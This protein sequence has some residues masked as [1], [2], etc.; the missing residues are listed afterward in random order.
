RDGQAG[1]GTCEDSSVRAQAPAGADGGGRAGADEDQPFCKNLHCV[2]RNRAAFTDSTVGGAGHT[3][4]GRGGFCKNFQSATAPGAAPGS[5]PRPPG[6]E[7]TRTAGAMARVAAVVSTAEPVSTVHSSHSRA[8][9]ASPSTGTAT[10]P[11]RCQSRE[12]SRL[13]GLIVS[14]QVGK[15]IPSVV[16]RS[17][18]RWASAPTA[19]AAGSQNEV[20]GAVTA[21]SRPA[22][23]PATQGSSRPSTVFSARVPSAHRIVISS[24]A[25]ASISPS[26]GTRTCQSSPFTN[27]A[28]AV[29]ATTASSVWVAPRCPAARLTA[30]E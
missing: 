3:L 2:R 14:G 25:P 10:S 21:T 9:P 15:G 17:P 7:S 12:A 22:T 19:T 28:R 4:K 11:L 27:A 5:G 26:T 16:S 6:P 20:S 24:A 29:N 8:L 23:R 18:T 13:G 1:G 30:R